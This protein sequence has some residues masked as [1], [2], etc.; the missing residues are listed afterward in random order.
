MNTSLASVKAWIGQACCLQE[1]LPPR[2]SIGL[3]MGEPALVGPLGDV[4]GKQ[5][6]NARDNHL[7]Q[8]LPTDQVTLLPR[9]QDDGAYEPKDDCQHGLFLAPPPLMRIPAL[10]YL[11]YS[12]PGLNGPLVR[13]M[14]FLAP[15]EHGC[16]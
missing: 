12:K 2:R 8:T 11:I 3:A 15:S 6:E 16:V 13:E 9:N 1:N 7:L 4:E 10:E 14:L 5:E